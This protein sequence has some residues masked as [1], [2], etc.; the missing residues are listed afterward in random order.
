[1]ET[2]GLPADLD[3]GRQGQCSTGARDTGTSDRDPGVTRPARRHD[4]TI[5]DEADAAAS[6]GGSVTP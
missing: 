1:M 3:T 2:F 5:A 6:S 4:R